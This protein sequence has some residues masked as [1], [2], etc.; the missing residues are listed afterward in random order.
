M[1][2]RHRNLLDRAH[3]LQTHS[4]PRVVCT[5]S[6]TPRKANPDQY[7]KPFRLSEEDTDRIQRQIQDTED[8]IA[9]ETDNFKERRYRALGEESLKRKSPEII[10]PSDEP[11]SANQAEPDL[12]SVSVAS[13]EANV[14]ATDTQD[15]PIVANKEITVI[16]S[17]PDQSRD[18]LLKGDEY[19]EGEEDSV[20][21]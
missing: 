17:S 8:Q 18:Y 12:K 7:Y 2:A 11:K 21:Y 20:I 14:S 13:P 4:H 16:V 19:V 9:D 1:N 5:G 3:S 10:P 6:I 15:A